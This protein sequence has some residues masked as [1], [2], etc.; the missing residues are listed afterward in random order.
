MKSRFIII[1]ITNHIIWRIYLKLIY[2]TYF[3]GGRGRGLLFSV[4][5][6]ISFS[7]DPSPSQ[8]LWLCFSEQANY[9]LMWRNS[10]MDVS[11]PSSLGGLPFFSLIVRHP[12]NILIPIINFSSACIMYKLDLQTANHPAADILMRSLC[13]LTTSESVPAYSTVSLYKHY[14]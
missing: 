7:L 3:L 9:L 5:N 13:K 14:H 4:L 12:S 1:K 10:V 11:S 8:G 2:I 6:S